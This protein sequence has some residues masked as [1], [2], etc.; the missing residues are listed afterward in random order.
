MQMNPNQQNQP[1][2]YGNPDMYNQQNMNMGVNNQYTDVSSQHTGYNGMNANNQVQMQMPLYPAN[3][4]QSPHINNWYAMKYINILFCLTS[5]A[6]SLTLLIAYL[7]IPG[8]L[9]IVYTSYNFTFH[10]LSPHRKALTLK[11]ACCINTFSAIV[12]ILLLVNLIV[13]FV[14]LDG[15]WYLERGY[16]SASILVVLISVLIFNAIFFIMCVQT[17]VKMYLPYIQGFAIIQPNNQGGQFPQQQYNGSG[18]FQQPPMFKNQQPVQYGQ[19]IQQQQPAQFMNQQ[20]PPMYQQQQPLMMNGVQKPM[21][22]QQQSQMPLYQA[23]APN[24]T[25]HLNKT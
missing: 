16:P 13:F 6:L 12:I 22:N 11:N 1:P 19:P 17:E 14:A 25:S 10:L 5:L 21:I 24:F 15:L 23:L 4:V 20:Q 2:L 7:E 18:G 3:P 8:I 9:Y